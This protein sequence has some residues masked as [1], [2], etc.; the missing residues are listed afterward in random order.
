M[1][2][3]PQERNDGSE[4][5]AE[6]VS[7]SEIFWSEVLFKEEMKSNEYPTSNEVPTTYVVL[8]LNTRFNVTVVGKWCIVNSR[9]L[10]VRS[11]L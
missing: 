3:Y 2:K 8:L 5:K 10:S 6:S 11:L 1:M 9:I 7:I 4:S